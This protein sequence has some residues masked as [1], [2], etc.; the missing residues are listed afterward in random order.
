MQKIVFIMVGSSL[1]EMEE[2]EAFAWDT[3]NFEVP[4]H[5]QVIV[6]PSTINFRP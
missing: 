2:A 4:D 3:E 6:V 5:V 1:S